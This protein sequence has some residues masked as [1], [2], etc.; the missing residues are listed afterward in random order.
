MSGPGQQ[1]KIR[2]SVASPV[3]ESRA[4]GVDLR[5][6]PPHD[7]LD[8]NA[9]PVLVPSQATPAI[10]RI[11]DYC[12][13]IV[14]A[15]QVGI[16]VIDNTNHTIFANLKMAT[17]FG[18]TIDQ[19][20][21]KLLSDLT[22][23]VAG[24]EYPQEVVFPRHGEGGTGE[25]LLHHQNGSEIWTEIA[26]IPLMNDD[27]SYHGALMTVT[28]ISR[29]KLSEEA[30]QRFASI[31]E[32][33]RDAIVSKSLD[34]II[35][36]WNPAA[37]RFYGFTA[38]EAIGQHVS[39]IHHRA[40]ISEDSSVMD[41]IRSGLAID[42][43]EVEC[44]RKD[45][46][47]ILVAQ[48]ISPIRDTRGHITVASVTARDITKRAL[49]LGLAQS[50]A[51]AVEQERL[52]ELA[53]ERRVTEF[54]NQE[55]ARC[56]A[57][58]NAV[59]ANRAKSAFLANM[60]HE[61][62][63]PLNAIIGFSQML[64]D[65]LFGDLNAKQ[66]R[67][68]NHILQGGQHLLT[69]INEILDL[70]TIEAGK[71]QLELGPVD[72][73]VIA[74]DVYDTIHA[75]AAGKQLSLI[76]KVPSL[77]FIGDSGR[78]RQILLNLVANAIKFTPSG[79]RIEVDATSTED[80]RGRTTRIRV[81]DS[82]IGINSNDL[83]RL[84]VEFSR[85]DDSY[86]RSTEGSG[87]GLALTKR[88]VELHGGHITVESA[89]LG[90]GTTFTVDF[91][92]GSAP[93]RSVP[94]SLLPAPIPTAPPPLAPANDKTD[95]ATTSCEKRPA[96]GLILVVDD[97]TSA[98]EV[99]TD[100]LPSD[101]YEV[102]I[103]AD[104]EMALAHVSLRPPT[105]VILDIKLAGG[106]FGWE[107]LE[108]L[109]ASP[110]TRNIPVIVLSM[111]DERT[112]ARSLGADEALLKP[113]D[114]DQL[115]TVIN[116]AVRRQQLNRTILVVDEDAM[117]LK[118]VSYIFREHGW[119][120]VAAS[121]SDEAIGLAA[122]QVP[123][124]AIVKQSM[125]DISGMEL[126]ERWSGSPDTALMPVLIHGD[127]QLDEHERNRMDPLRHGFVMHLHCESLLAEADRLCDLIPARN[128]RPPNNDSA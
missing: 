67:Q 66:T 107:I 43:M 41:R 104:V 100:V 52:R 124:I 28:D 10:E 1:G 106:R 40:M 69:L 86:A 117:I 127:R 60:S 15:A 33:S 29:R 9:P 65:R 120:V 48:N 35:L 46:V 71:I 90:Q 45:G 98:Q 114:R 12:R 44:V 4:L 24:L 112:R 61:L 78:I 47:R 125:P 2:Q 109:K 95:Q 53:E 121:S 122:L 75:L 116:T 11:V 38:A 105:A 62:R 3:T 128:T 25:V 88:L 59:S 81:H 22:N 34:G 54:R 96:R 108:A 5:C 94:P 20:Q 79:G 84:F 119:N 72:L 77:R 42:E 102:L 14:A 110:Q 73:H 23:D 101:R 63:T 37:V 83:D 31:V 70:S 64:A 97:E 74:S 19:M 111:L 92:D 39:L 50:V 8:R 36:S 87:L 103:A 99:V 55:V 89:G 123:D 56:L 68:V 27:G 26:T 126:V 80:E 118:Y 6:D 32:S 115:L 82:G 7:M 93:P 18:Y 58:S 76:M 57:V 91:P 51:L 17:M 113:V 21:G 85:L 30:L 16:W 13:R 49:E